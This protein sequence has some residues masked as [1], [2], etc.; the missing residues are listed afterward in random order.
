MKG[1]KTASTLGKATK[2]GTAG[3]IADVIAKDE[4]EQHLKPIMELVNAKGINKEVDELVNKLDI[5]PDDTV[6]ERLLKQI[7]DSTSLAATFGISTAL[8]FGILVR[9]GSKAIGKVKAIKKD[10][11][12]TPVT[13]T[14]DNVA[15]NV[16]VVQQSPGQFLQ[17]GTMSSAVAKINT[18]LGRIFRSKAAM[19]DQLFKAY[20]K[21][22]YYL[23]CVI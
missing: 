6:S 18:K 8:A 22:I 3:V 21:K 5:N 19:P 15:S 1:I 14:A 4:N 2:Y 23:L 16:Q 20:I 7:I 10:K 17:K 12:T 9:G 11:I 13:N